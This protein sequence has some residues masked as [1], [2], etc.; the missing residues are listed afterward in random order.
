MP[1]KKYIVDLTGQERLEL[2]KLLKA[3]KHKSRKLTRARI[4]LLA[5]KG[6]TD[7]QIVEALGTSRQPSSEPEDVLLKK[8]GNVCMNIAVREHVP[9]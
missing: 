6:R 9:V 1:E 8:D 7:A 2:E 4:L 5:G 3:G